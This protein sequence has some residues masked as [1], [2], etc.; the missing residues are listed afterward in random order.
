[1]SPPYSIGQ[2]QALLA[3]SRLECKHL[4]RNK[5]SSLFGLLVSDEENDIYNMDP[6]RLYYKNGR[7][8]CCIIIS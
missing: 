6:W 4:Q 3:N 1:M 5:L 7:N 2:A 8:C